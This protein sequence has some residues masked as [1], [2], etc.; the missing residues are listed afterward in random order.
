MRDKEAGESACYRGMWNA[1]LPK[2]PSDSV[3]QGPSQGDDTIYF[4]HALL[5]PASSATR[6][7]DYNRLGRVRRFPRDYMYFC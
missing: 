4:T 2:L 3:R 1:T 7:Y 6:C 5:V